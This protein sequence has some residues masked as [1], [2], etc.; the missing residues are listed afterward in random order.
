MTSGPSA[1][2]RQRTCLTAD[3]HRDLLLQDPSY[4]AARREI[5]QF[6]RAFETATARLGQRTG[7]VVIPVVVHV[8]WNQ[9][10]EN[11]SDAQ[12]MSQLGVLNAD[13]RR[14]NADAGSA[15]AAFQPL[16]ADA[17]IQFQ[18]AVRDPHC[19]PTTGILRRQTNV[20]GFPVGNTQS[21]ADNPVKF[22]ALG[23][24]D[25]WPRDRYLN[26]W[27]CR[28]QD[29]DLLGYAT[30]PGYPANVDGVVMAYTAFGT[31]GSATP[32]FHLGR[33]TTHEVGH[34]LNLFHSFGNNAV[35]S[36][37]D[38]DEV[39]DTPNQ[40]GPNL[41]CP[42][43]PSVSCNDGPDGDMFM[44][45]MDYV[46]DDC[47]VMF[48]AGQAARMNAALAG[49]RAA[50]LASDALVPPQPVAGPDLWS[51]DLPLDL[52]IEP[53]AAV[54][55]MWASDDVWVRRQ[56][57]G[58]TIQD[59]ENPEYRPP[60]DPPNWVYVRVRNRGCQDAARGDVKLYWAKASTALGWPAPF[61]GSVTTP[62]VM[63]GPIGSQPTGAV[64]AGGFTVLKFP[65]SP[66]DPAGYASFGG[67]AAHF[68][69]LSRIETDPA[70]PY[71]MAFA[72]GPDL[73]LNVQRNN[74]IVWKNL[75]VV[76]ELEDGSRRA[77]VVVDGLPQ[78]PTKLVIRAQAARG[79]RSVLDWA[80]VE[81]DLG[82][83]LYGAWQESGAQ[84]YGVEAAGG[85]RVAVR[86]RRAFLDNLPLR[87][88]DPQTLV[89]L[90]QPR[91]DAP[92]QGDVFQL[93]IEHYA[94][95]D[96]G[97]QLVGGQRMVVK[98]VT[99]EPEE[100]VLDRVESWD[101]LVLRERFGDE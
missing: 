12:I 65:W 62:A 93:D 51:A 28:F 17:R 11:V 98:T 89:V 29:P 79:R 46:Q 45:Y 30:F 73:Y 56:D 20:S 95:D 76:D 64:P 87:P 74:N 82:E 97:D 1:T 55:P 48:S 92:A 32:P 60:G 37:S 5:M 71:G 35:P 99:D 15:P 75:T 10:A 38:S 8:V 58:L 36:C 3:Q 63:G 53:D 50:I 94:S 85:T 47:M 13:Y 83:R 78:A 26:L 19:Q 21:A 4:R 57:D 80:R 41:G 70:P 43:F 54:G 86:R 91:P 2:P 77:A 39:A 72:E 22:T 33:T 61:D 23:G 14:L 88:G 25:A 96:D 90:V 66:P 49:P 27:V 7:I 100:G 84:G 59:H 9:P 52:G 44:N 31:I 18:L 67:D 16:A 24:D 42:G 69:L 101:E 68:C 6:T 81:L 34:W 40:R